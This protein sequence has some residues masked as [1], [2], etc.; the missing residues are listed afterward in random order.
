M[1][2]LINKTEGKLGQRTFGIGHDDLII[3]Y[4]AHRSIYQKYRAIFQYF[5]SLLIGLTATPQSEV[6]RNTRASSASRTT[7]PRSLMSSVRPSRPDTSCR[8]GSCRFR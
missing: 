8:P 1:M 2:N 6:D 4:E 7:F 5:D 3:V